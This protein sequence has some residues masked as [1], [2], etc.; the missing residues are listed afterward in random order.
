[1]KFRRIN[2]RSFA[3]KHGIKFAYA[4]LLRQ[5]SI[6]CIV[7]DCVIKGFTRKEL[8]EYVISLVAIL[9]NDIVVEEVDKCKI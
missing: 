9:L 4:E 3:V 7:N 8:F 6:E 2:T 5:S 1:M